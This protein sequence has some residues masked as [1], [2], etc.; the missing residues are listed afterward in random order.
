MSYEYE[1]VR[2]LVPFGVLVDICDTFGYF[3]GLSYL[4]F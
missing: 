4:I 2:Y 1:E 3:E